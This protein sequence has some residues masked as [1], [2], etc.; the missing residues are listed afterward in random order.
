MIYKRSE[1]GDNIG[2]TTII[3]DKFKSSSL[4]V[5]FLTELSEKTAAVN[6][7]GISILTVSSR[8]YNT[9]ALLCEKLSELY[10]AG[11]G[12]IARKKGDAQILGLKASWL[13]NKYAIDGEDICGEMRQLIH[14]CLF[15]PNVSNC[16]FD[17]DS[18][19]IVKKDLIDRIDGELNQK[20]SYA[21]SQAA[22]VAFRGEPAEC[23]GYGSREAA[24]NASP[25]DA[26][27]AYEELLKTAQIEIY[28]VSPH[29]DSSFAEMFTESFGMIERAP[30]KVS[31]R[32]HSPLKP[33]PEHVSEEFDVNQC[34]MV[35]AFKTD[36]D[37]KYALKMLSIIYGEMPFSKLFLNVREKLSLCY[38]CVSTSVSA[39][40]TFFVDSGIE[41]C[42][43]DKARDEILAQL[44]EIKNGNIT[45]EEIESSLMA[46]DNAVL[47]IGDTASSYI[48]WFFDCFSDG[49]LITP[50]EHFRE[51]RAVTKERI[52]QA[53]NS[54][55][56][57]TVYLM[58]DKEVQE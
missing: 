48:N 29:E 35:L 45:D 41:R 17:A 18:F 24:S 22:K 53:A 52:V 55:K 12:S 42:N 15:E 54:L 2:F 47:Q 34:K 1:L 50:E 31:I 56:L 20:R 11:L 43:I 13:D 44:E 57:D 49:K 32:N 7:L 16:A 5:Y 36:S 23:T 30:R 51:F 40:G 26:Y 8:Q 33:E 46:L 25:E 10:G 14:G 4:A 37:D 39:K 21:I 58:L 19:N 3:D 28:Y 6:N 38:Y 9:Y 27:R